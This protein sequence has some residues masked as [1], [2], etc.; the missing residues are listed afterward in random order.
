MHDH[1]FKGQRKDTGEWVRGE[2]ITSNCQIFIKTSPIIDTQISCND[3]MM[4]S[5]FVYEVIWDTVEPYIK[6]EEEI[7]K[8]GG[9]YV[10]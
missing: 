1:R 3:G 8:S 10:A 2:L 7:K 9:C 4:I 6:P 5:V